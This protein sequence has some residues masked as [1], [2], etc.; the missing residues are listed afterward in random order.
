MQ[1]LIVHAGPLR[2]WCSNNLHLERSAVVWVVRTIPSPELGH[3]GLIV[4]P[5][6]S[7]LVPD[8]AFAAPSNDTVVGRDVF[9][10]ESTVRS[11]CIFESSG[12]D[13]RESAVLAIAGTYGVANDLHPLPWLLHGYE[14]ARRYWSVDEDATKKCFGLLTDLDFMQA[15]TQI[16]D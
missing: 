6:G 7:N 8:N 10:S 16:W 1:R 4:V 15:M 9:G 13:A 12:V 2:V 11:R 5:S 3:G 14:V